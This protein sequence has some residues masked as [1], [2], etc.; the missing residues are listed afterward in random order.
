MLL[1]KGAPKLGHRMHTY[2]Q[3]CKLKNQVV[4]Q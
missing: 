1:K 4:K 3:L 2:V